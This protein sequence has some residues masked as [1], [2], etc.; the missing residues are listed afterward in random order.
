[1]KDVGAGKRELER[2]CQSCLWRGSF[3]KD[4]AKECSI[5]QQLKGNRVKGRIRSPKKDVAGD[6]L[7]RRAVA[8]L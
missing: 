3:V 6:T 4:V 5:P 7:T 1:M 8:H 2:L